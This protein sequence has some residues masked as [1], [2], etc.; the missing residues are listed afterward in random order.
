[1]LSENAGRYHTDPVFRGF[2]LNALKCSLIAN[3]S[4]R[5]ETALDHG[6]AQHVKLEHAKGC[7]LQQQKNRNATEEQKQP[8]RVLKMPAKHN[9]ILV[10]LKGK[11][12]TNKIRIGVNHNPIKY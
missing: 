12:T 7:T 5:K 8:H 11:A 6:T 4:N 1:M 2:F 9:C 10:F 3:T